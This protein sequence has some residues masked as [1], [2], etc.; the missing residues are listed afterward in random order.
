LLY[1]SLI[2][3]C[4]IG[5][6]RQ[7]I[8]ILVAHLTGQGMRINTDF[9]SNALYLCRHSDYT[10]RF[11]IKGPGAKA[12]MEESRRSETNCDP[13]VPATVVVL[14]YNTP[15]LLARCLRSFCEACPAKGWQ[16]IVVDNGSDV[17]MRPSIDGRFDGVE[18]IR[19]ERNLGFAA[20]NN[21]G[22][23]RAKG[24]FV[25]L[26]N[27]DVLARAE[28]L[29]SLVEAMRKAPRAGAMSPG[30]HT[31]QGKPQ[32]FAFGADNSPV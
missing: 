29:E 13:A 31:A 3:I 12:D 22:L 18:S 28:V 30:L 19:S 21:L 8:S 4:L 15:D 11:K 20:G 14:V 2:Y 23:R 25:V 9:S 16:I 1:P 26:M 27:S 6:S 10:G 7:N 17:D 24:E 32:A 5:A